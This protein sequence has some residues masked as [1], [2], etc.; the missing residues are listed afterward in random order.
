MGAIFQKLWLALSTV[1]GW[2]AEQLNISEEST[3]AAIDSKTIKEVNQKC[4][5]FFKKKSNKIANVDF[6]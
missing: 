3:S 1:K 6:T 5:M 4:K 2:K